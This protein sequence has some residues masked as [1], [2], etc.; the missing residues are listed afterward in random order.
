MKK[1][2][3]LL[4]LIPVLAYAANT[5]P[6]G[7]NSDI[8]YNNNG[9]WGPYKLGTGLSVTTSGSNK[10]LNST[11][12]S[13]TSALGTATTANP[14]ITSDFSSGFF[15]PG[16]GRVAVEALTTK[17][18][19]W[20]STGVTVPSL[21][22]NA[23]V[24]TTSGSLLDNIQVISPLVLTATSLTLPGGG[25][26]TP[27]GPAGGNLGGN[28]PNPTVIG[29]TNGTTLS[30][31][32]LVITTSSGTV[33]NVSTGNG[34]QLSTTSLNAIAATVTSLGSVIIGT[35]LNVSTTGVASGAIATTT[36]QGEV[37]IGAGLNISTTGVASGAIATT[38]GQGEIIPSTGLSISATGVTTVTDL[39]VVTTGIH[40]SQQ[41]T[42]GQAGSALYQTASGGVGGITAGTIA[43]VSGTVQEFYL[44]ANLLYQMTQGMTVDP[45]YY[46]AACNTKF[47]N[48][49]YFGSSSH[50]IRTTNGSPVISI[51]GYT[52]KNCVSAPGSDCDVGRLISIWGGVDGNVGPTTYIAS[53]DTG[54]N[55]ATLGANMQATLTSPGQGSAAVLGGYPQSSCG[56]ASTTPSLAADDTCAI[57]NASASSAFFHGGKVTLP[58]GCMVHGLTLADG[59]WLDGNNGGNGYNSPAGN[60]TNTKLYFATNNYGDDPLIGINVASAVSQNVRLSNITFQCSPFPYLQF[61]GGTTF[62]AVG[63]RTPINLA[64]EGAAIDHDT[65][66]LC[67]VGFGI[68]FGLN[69]SVSFTA[70]IAGTTMTVSSIDSTNFHDVYTLGAN[71]TPDWLALGRTV[72]GPGV[73]AGT[74][75]TAVPASN[76]VGAYTVSL[77]QTVTS[78]SMT[79]PVPQFFMA[80]QSRDSQF[81]YNS[82][83][84]NGDE[85]DYADVNSFF[86]GNKIAGVWIGPNTGG[87]TGNAANRFSLERVE[88]NERNPAI[89]IDG[90]A[91]DVFTG[92][93]CQFNALG[94]IGTRGTWN[95][96]QITGGMSQGDGSAATPS[97]HFILG[98]TGTGFYVSGMMTIKQNYSGGGNSAYLFATTTG[99][100]VDYVSIEGGD[101]KN[102]FNTA[103]TDFSRS[104]V[105]HYKQ[106]A[107]GIAS[108]DNTQSALSITSTGGVGIGT[109]APTNGTILDLFSATAT[110]NSSLGVPKGT[111]ANRPSSPVAGMFRYNTNLSSFEGYNGSSWGAVGGTTVI[112]LSF[113]GLTLS[114]D[115]GSPNTVVDIAYGGA[116]SDDG[117]TQ[118]L[119]GSAVTKSTASWL[120]GSG[121]GCLDTGGV[122]NSTW[123][124]LFLIERLDTGVVDVLCSTSATAPTMPTGYTVKR[125]IGSFKTDGS[126][127]IITFTQ[128]GTAYYWTTPTLDVTTT[129]LGTSAALQTLNVPSGVQITPL[130]E[131]SISNASVPVSVYL[132]SSDETDLATTVT[133]PFSA[134]PGYSYLSTTTTGQPSNAACPFLTTNTS[135]QIRSRASAASTLLS[136]ITR[137][138]ID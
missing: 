38:T 115:G 91:I 74:T 51:D 114:N 42:V 131:A 49:G 26:S 12:T 73:T 72:S 93:N 41:F 129:T 16:A 9:Q 15:T 44:A 25:S 68:P 30:S 39:G 17:A 107:P 103:M 121:N 123:Y 13:S 92:L 137:G 82:I 57:H 27:T 106:I 46:G 50:T 33:N 135:S 109:A 94:C 104:A 58:T 108:I 128:V 48:T 112:P 61:F 88:E 6:P 4:L 45:R 1:L 22:S 136:I 125:R 32:A 79:S 56:I 77:S 31:N 117:T 37:I 113:G 65:F 3:A 138:W 75:I 21:T 119:L 130:C 64:S 2:L 7:S 35:G 67:P 110:T 84:I 70:S 55:T 105:S 40:D 66:N 60:N 20:T 11:T 81:S 86:T 102:S 8:P 14:Y 76:R 89:M 28:Y 52:F 34:L 95:D 36:G 127:N 118:M 96:I 87:S 69:Q 29:L 47:F 59:T 122:A 5:P 90:S 71:T 116:A 120:V 133:S 83:G 23:L 53:V 85:S 134:S 98:G 78:E 62:A 18:M 97:A 100:S 101:V 24:G 132:T 19:E 63:A 80:G 10:F 54:A 126:A 124:H 43:G 111:S 99:S